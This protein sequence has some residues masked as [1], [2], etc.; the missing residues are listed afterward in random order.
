MS[1][2]VEE[3][4]RAPLYQQIKDY[5]L[6]RILS[7]DWAVDRRIPSENELVREMGASRMTINRAL[8]ELT[9]EGRLRRV[10][11]VGTFVADPRPQLELLRIRNIAD[12]IRGRGHAHRSEVIFLRETVLSDEIAAMLKL[13]SGSRAFHS[14]L[15][16]RENETPMQLEE[17]YVNPTV[18]PDYLSV[19][20]THSTPNEYLMRVAPLGEVEHSLEA[21]LPDADAQRHLEI[22]PAEPC[23]LLH[24]RTWSRDHV[25]SRAWL[26]HPGSR[27]RISAQF[28]QND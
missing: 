28:T 19:D 3:A 11:G 16:H 12:E 15:V 14:L 25:A 24:R 7:G 2:N 18:A 17:R 27:Y 26:T 22:G 5:V 20:F 21:V 4:V 1:R 13:A 6:S 10:Q 8:R 23:L 9:A